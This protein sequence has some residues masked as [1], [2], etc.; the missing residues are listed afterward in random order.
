MPL[1]GKLIMRWCFIFLIFVN[2][3]FFIW[4]SQQP[5]IT[6][7]ETSTP[8]NHN[9]NA[10]TII[11]LKEEPSRAIKKTINTTSDIGTVTEEQHSTPIPQP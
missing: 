8:P 7:T 11:L 2:L 10:Q 9:A 1:H 6:H 3:F 5:D 4:Q